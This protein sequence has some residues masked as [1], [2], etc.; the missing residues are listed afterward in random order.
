M[1]EE[2]ESVVWERVNDNVITLRELQ[3]RGQELVN[4][5]NW[6]LNKIRTGNSLSLENR[7]MDCDT[8]T[9]VLEA[10]PSSS[11]LPKDVTET[12]MIYRQMTWLLILT[13]PFSIPLS[14]L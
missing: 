6:I 13:I 8:L 5:R 12:L 4:K 14:V 10:V 11:G 9:V 7:V 1:E 3:N 2:S